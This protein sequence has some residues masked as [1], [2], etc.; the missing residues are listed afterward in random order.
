MYGIETVQIIKV[1]Y[2]SFER[3][4]MFIK[5]KDFAEHTAFVCLIIDTDGMKRIDVVNLED[6]NKKY[7]KYLKQNDYCAL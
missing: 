3:E 5:S 2:Q 6:L 4:K 7:A 1:L